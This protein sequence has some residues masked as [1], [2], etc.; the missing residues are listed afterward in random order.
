M[1][2]LFKPLPHSEAAAMISTLPPLLRSEYDNLLPELR[3]YAFTVSGLTKLGAI[4]EARQTLADVALGDQTWAQAKKDLTGK[5]SPYLETGPAARR[6]ELLLRTHTF[7]GYAATRYRLLMAQRAA[8]PY[9]QY[10]THGD[11]RVRPS[12]AALNGKILPAGHPLWQKIF[13][14]WGWGCRCLVVPRTRASVEGLRA[15]DEG[16]APEA[17]VIWEGDL[18]DAIESAQRLPSGISL[19]E[20]KNWNWK[21]GELRPDLGELKKRY[22][23]NDPEAWAAFEAWAKGMGTDG[24]KRGRGDKGTGSMSL[25]AWLSGEQ[26]KPGR[27]RKAAAAVKKAKTLPEAVQEFEQVTGVKVIFDRPSKNMGWGAKMTQAETVKH[28]ETVGAEWQRLRQVFPALAGKKVEAF[29]AR[30]SQRGLAH[31]N[32]PA[33]HLA[34]K[35]EEW[36]PLSWEAIEKW[37]KENGRKWGTERRGSQVIDNFR[38]ELGHNLSTPKIMDRFRVISRTGGYDLSWFR[39]N[40]SEYSAT[41][42]RES[43][44]EL[45]GILTRAEYVRGTYPASLEQFVF[46]TMLGA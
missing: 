31:V 30:R 7:R 9:W 14:P 18:A 2:L 37:E 45:F 23:E 22:Q 40:V 8:F 17:K 26:V 29:V 25:W 13:P 33:P 10:K 5:L 46:E 42:D 36:S 20:E 27:T 38:H 16:K 11:G 32:G 28:L 15:G 35:A 19:P 41:N 1:D 3:A 43:V 34:T 39:Q 44:A 6:A 12:H 21:P 4:V 24:E